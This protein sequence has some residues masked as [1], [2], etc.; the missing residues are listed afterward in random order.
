MIILKLGGSLLTDKTK[1]F[2]IR[3]KVLRRVASEIKAA[4]KRVIIVHGGGSFGHPIASK[5]GLSEG[6]RK[7]SQLQGVALTRAAMGKFNQM[8]VEALVKCG[9]NAVSLQP[10]ANIVCENRRIKSFDTSIL[11]KFIS[12]GITPV[13][14]GDVVLDTRQKFCILSGDQ[15]VSYLA[16]VF[17]PEKV[18]FAVDVDGIFDK[19]PKKYRDA[20]LVREIDQR[21]YRKILARIKPLKNDVTGGIRGKILELLRLA[22][23]GYESHIINALAAGRLKKSLLGIEVIGTVIRSDNYKNDTLKKT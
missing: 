2:S 3:T 17:K 14:Y 15:I 20:K 21:N 23:K 13:L 4:D 9:I 11:K 6:F 8:V 5:Y 18:I 12:L 1:K 10:S 7:K 16:G 19:N 22:G